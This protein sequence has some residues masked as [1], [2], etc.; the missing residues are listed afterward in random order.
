MKAASSCRT[1]RLHACQL[2]AFLVVLAAALLAGCGG[3][4]THVAPTISQPA[5]ITVQPVNQVIPIS[6]TATFT[7][8]ATGTAPLSYQWSE[9]G[10][11]ISGATSATYTTPT[12]ALDGSGSTLI[13]SFDVTVSNAAGSVTSNA[14]TLNAGPRSPKAG[15]LRYLLLEQVNLPGL[16][17]T[18]VLPGTDNLEATYP[19]AVGTP[20]MMGECSLIDGCGWNADTLNLPPP[21]TGLTMNY[22]LGFNNIGSNYP[23]NP[24]IDSD[25][26]SVA[27]PNA[28]ITSLDI[29][30]PMDT[31]AMSW[32]QTAQAGGFDYRLEKIPMGTNLQAEIQ[33]AAAAD[34]AESRVI[35]AVSF[36]DTSQ[37]AYL[38]SY[39]W[40]GDTTTVY[41]TQ[42]TV[43]T[44]AD[45][46]AAAVTLASEGYVISAFGG[47][48]I[49]GYVLIGMRVQGDSLPRP[50]VAS[51]P[52]GTVLATNPDSASIYF[53]T[54][55]YL[56]AL[57]VTEQ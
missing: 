5:A 9:N 38:I 39:G 4:A 12:I 6:D 2:A 1:S 23:T 19:N 25:L 3:G 32:V 8:T 56:N 50:N 53:T 26:Q 42:T 45:V 28:V 57:I 16:G 34:G 11:P 27:T 21:M 24:T 14:V 37:M 40:T 44:H 41:E 46:R 49:D 36:D 47:N 30:T 51:D 13:G 20:L 43:A 52:S 55:V 29:E 18:G 54:V 35:T 15:D 31:Y 10:V 7:V 48:D 33:A 22:N 17:V